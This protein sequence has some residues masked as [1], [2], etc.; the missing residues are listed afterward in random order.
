MFRKG[1]VLILILLFSL[2]SVALA[3]GFTVDEK[4]ALDAQLQKDFLRYSTLGASVA[5]IQNGEVVYT[6]CYGVQKP[7]GDP[8]VPECG[9]QVGSISKMVANIGL[10]QLVEQGKADLDDEIGDLLGLAFR[11]PYAPNQPVTLRQVMTHTAGLRDSAYYDDALNGNA[12]SLEELLQPNKIKNIFLSNVT[13]GEK[14]VYSNFGGGLIGSLIELLSGQTIDD[15]MTENVFEPLEMTAAFQVSRLPQSLPLCDIY[16]MPQKTLGK[17]L[18]DDLTDLKAPDYQRHYYVTAGKLIL[19]APDLAKLLI[20]LCDGGVWGNVRLL[21]ESTVREMTTLQ[22]LR[23]SVHCDSNR[24]L[25]LNILT[26]DEVEGR[27]LYGH[28]GKAYGMLCA[29]YFDPLDR[30]GVVML[31]NGCNNRKNYHNVGMLGRAVLTDVYQAVE[32][33]GYQMKSVYQV[34]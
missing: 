2:S 14:S 5:L 9:F 13:P 28:G 3:D 18:R 27:T 16:F 11:S 21:K 23:G 19:S 17:K 22:N 15:Y 4:A 31:T 26:D 29:A 20:A 8:V 33:S 10:M 6:Y 34:E 1:A 30:T 24:G 32:A 7:G 12:L 25:F